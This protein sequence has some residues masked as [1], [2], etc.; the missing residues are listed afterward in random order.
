MTLWF[1]QINPV[2]QSYPKRFGIIQ[3]NRFNSRV[4][5]NIESG[6]QIVSS[7]NWQV[8]KVCCGV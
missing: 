8:M 4:K 1:E 5:Q 7:S 2:E 3:K 6:E